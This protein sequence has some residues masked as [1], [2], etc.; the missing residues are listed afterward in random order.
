MRVSL[1][2]FGECIQTLPPASYA[3]KIP[4]NQSQAGRES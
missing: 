4:K 3:D 2:I 1:S